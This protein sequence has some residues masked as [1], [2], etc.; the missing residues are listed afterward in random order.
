MT[1]TP[2]TFS[3]ATPTASDSFSPRV[4]VTGASGYVGG[5]LVPKLLDAGYTVRTTRRDDSTSQ[6]WWSD[7]VET[8][9]MDITN[10]DQVN[11]ACQDVD[12]VYY[13]VHGMGGD[14]FVEKDRQA[15]TIVRAAADAAGVT[16][17]VYLS[18]LIPND[19]DE[20]ELSDHLSSRLEVEKILSNARA[21]VITLRA[22]VLMGSG[23][24]SF[25]VIRQISERMPLQTV[26]TWMN[27]LVQP[28]AITDTLEALVAAATV[29]S[30][31]RSY[32]IGGP[33]TLSYP[34]LLVR[35]SDVASIERP[36][37][38]V[39]LLPTGLVSF[40][41]ARLTDVP[42][43]VVESLLDSLHHDMVCQEDDFTRDLLPAGYR[44]MGLRESIER[45]LADPR[46]SDSDQNT[47]N[48]PDKADPMGPMPHDP[49]WASGGDEP[50]LGRIA[51]KV[52]S[53]IHPNED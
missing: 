40:L 45:S 46:R 41:A 5:R 11:A 21:T 27:H 10:A 38:D 15:A 4:L 39:P 36:Q 20:S 24:T 22:A 9:T 8:V 19:V 12:I 50:L 35:Y 48:D 26:P 25:E 44:L 33:E 32:D 14:D 7:R 28:I 34:D 47:P 49:S 53:V 52:R 13:L 6:P 43:P 42:S 29:D 51:D 2:A 31:T 16:R 3:A 37:V 30:V 23:S 1:T 18:G 17:I